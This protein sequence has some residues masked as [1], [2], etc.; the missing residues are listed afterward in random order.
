MAL[1]AKKP[2]PD[3]NLLFAWQGMDRRGQRVKGETPGSDEAS[4]RA[5]LRRQGINPTKIR[6]TSKGLGGGKKKITYSKK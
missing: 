3:K 2:D 4:V 6:K 1:P 5:D